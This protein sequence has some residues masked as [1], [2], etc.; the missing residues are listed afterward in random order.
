MVPWMVL[1]FV[2]QQFPM[3]SASTSVAA[4]KPVVRT[5][6]VVHGSGAVV[7]MGDMV[8][9]EIKVVSGGKV[10][11]DT[12]SAGVPFT[13]I[14]GDSKVPTFLSNAAVGLQAKGSRSFTVPADEAAA[15]RSPGQT[16]GSNAELQV[17]IKVISVKS[18]SRLG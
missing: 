8:C 9:A 6:Q 17:S 7:K 3:S 12:F 5:T 1:L 13:F 4:A 16:P 18:P 10:L 11:L 14:V 2:A 15:W